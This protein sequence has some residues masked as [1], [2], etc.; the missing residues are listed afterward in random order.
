MK[1][2]TK[3]VIAGKNYKDNYGSVNIPVHRTST[4]LFPT[5]DAYNEAEKGNS[6]YKT[7]GSL[8]TDYSYG[9]SGTPTNFALQNAICEIEGAQYCLIYPSG[10]SAI[11]MTLLS[12]LQTG[13]HVLISDSIYG[14]TRRF[15]NKELTRLGIETT[16]Y[17]P[18]IGS[19]ISK[20]IKKNTKVIFTESPGSLTFEIQD[21]PAITKVAKEKNITTVIDNSWATSI[22][23]DPFK[24]GID[25]ALQ[26]GT[27]YIGGHSDIL[28]GTVTTN[29]TN[30]YKSLMRS[31]RNY[32]VHVSPDDCYLAIRGLRTMGVRLKAHQETALKLAKW[33]EN[34]ADVTTI[35]HPAFSSC[36]GHEIWKRDFSGSTGLFSFILDKKYSKEAIAKMVDNMQ[37]FGIGASWGGFESLIMPIDPSSIRT[38]SK[39][40]HENSCI[41]IYAGLEDAG[42]IIN[43]LEKGL[44]RLR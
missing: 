37:I 42:D 5:L 44:E 19:E 35:L 22:Y 40:P 33:L 2:E 39:W 14:P 12:L 4:V 32:G 18:L 6:C 43:D 17:D 1:K 25:I 29:D 7:Q 16:Y 31:H 15:C 24:Y 30:L 38:A 8:L 28:I 21:I 9:I 3:L 20:L 34:R 13:D 23:F 10:L 36:P 27:K 11:S 26:A 41:R